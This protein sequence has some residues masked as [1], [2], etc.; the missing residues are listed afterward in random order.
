MLSIKSTD[1]NNNRPVHRLMCEINLNAIFSVSI[2]GD[3]KWEILKQK[4]TA[5]NCFNFLY[6]MLRQNYIRIQSTLQ[7]MPINM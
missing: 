4:K 2:A 7:K 5:E 3:F 1:W 6:D